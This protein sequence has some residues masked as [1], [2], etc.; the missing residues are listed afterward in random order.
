MHDS[1]ESAIFTG[2]KPILHVFGEG[3]EK[4]M[5]FNKKIGF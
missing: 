4:T 2:I 1:S 5:V 3:L